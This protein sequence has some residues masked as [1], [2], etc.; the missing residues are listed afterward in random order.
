MNIYIA[1][2][3]GHTDA[4]WRHFHHATYG[5]HNRYFTPFIRCDHGELR[6]QDLRDFLSPLNEGIDLEPQVIF[7][8]MTELDILLSRLA[9]AGATKVNLNMGC[10]F[11]L[12]T[13]KGRGAGF[14]R[15]VEECAGIPD[16]LARYPAMTYSVKMRLGYDDPAEWR[17]IAGILDSIELR[18][19]DVHPR[20]ARQQYGGDLHL[21]Q[22]ESI[23]AESRNPVV[24][25]GDIRTPADMR[26]I[27]S[28]Y[29]SAAGVMTARGVLGRPS[30]AAE[31]ES[32]N[33]WSRDKRI[34]MM[35]EFHGSL[36]D[37]YSST[38]C[39]EAQILSK[40]KPFWEYAEEEIGR[41]AWKAI[42]K[43]GNMAKYHSAVA[44]IEP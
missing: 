32:G 44:M 33:E 5:G 40:I 3:Q 37:H 35:L 38:L 34:G 30:L 23:L 16:V 7:R 15:N 31:S 41:K 4:A 12:Q 24:F 9:D 27:L 22:F 26:D 42:K 43:A 19:V 2:V 13:G 1:P 8:D 29:P 20:V 11:P 28:R 36:L 10:P 39:G 14:I 18:H 25:N 6:K 17:G 21:D